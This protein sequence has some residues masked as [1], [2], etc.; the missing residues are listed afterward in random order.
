MSLSQGL[1]EGAR[2]AGTACTSVSSPTCGDR[3]TRVADEAIVAVRE[4]IGSTY[5]DV[6]LP[7]KPTSTSRR[8]ARHA[9]EA[10][11]LMS[12]DRLMLSAIS[13]QP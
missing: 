6:A 13:V 2:S 7:E 11:C 3:S 9:D 5:G 12:F 10:Y 1:Y 8:S 4:T